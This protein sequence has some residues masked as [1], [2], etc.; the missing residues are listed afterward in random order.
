MSSTTELRP[1]CCQLLRHDCRHG[2]AAHSPPLAACP[3][4]SADVQGHA[5]CAG[6]L[7]RRVP[8]PGAQPAPGWP[9]MLRVDGAV[10]V[11]SRRWL[12]SDAASCTRHEAQ[13]ACWQK[14]GPTSSGAQRLPPTLSPR[15]SRGGGATVG[16][17]FSLVC[18]N[19]QPD[20]MCTISCHLRSSRG[21]ATRPPTCAACWRCTSAGRWVA[22]LFHPRAAVGGLGYRLA[23]G[24]GYGLL[25][26]LQLVLHRQ[27][28]PVGGVGA[29]GE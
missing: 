23:A 7:P 28:V 18:R 20:G 5:G 8:P 27:W 24:L 21:G 11:R 6:Q 2:R 1:A 29:G 4:L 26:G 19:A 17:C 12:A 22:Q 14:M 25:L 3:G 9:Q 16:T 15:G 10:A 13:S